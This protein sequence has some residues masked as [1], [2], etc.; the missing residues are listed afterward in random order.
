MQ[1]HLFSLFSSRLLQRLLL[2]IEFLCHLSNVVVYHFSDVFNE[3]IGRSMLHTGQTYTSVSIE[4][5]Q[6]AH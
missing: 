6:A 5:M 3:A 4:F 1:T 2:G